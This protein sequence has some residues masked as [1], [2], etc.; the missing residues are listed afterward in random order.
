MTGYTDLAALSAP[1]APVTADVCV[2][3]A[4]AAGLYLAHRLATRGLHVVIVEAGAAKCGDGASV[5][6]DAVQP[7]L[8]Y[9]GATAGRAF[10]LGG[11]TSRWGGLLVPHSE[12]DLR[13]DGSPTSLAW[14]HIV[15]V[16][17][18]RTASV[19]MA[20]G[21]GSRPEFF[22]F[23]DESL[24][25]TAALLRRHG[26]T[27]IASAF[28]PWRLRNLA[29]PGVDP[30]SWIH[31]RLRECHRHNVVLRIE[32]QRRRHRIRRGRIPQRKPTSARGRRV[33]RRRRG[34]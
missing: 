23:A 10:G 18:E 2:I 12:V 16:V 19:T 21:L 1:V 31:S 24:G 9:G 20:L 25:E 11:S 26:L 27:P 14:K 13:D 32:S 28:L 34:H 5:G 15:D 17:R 33:R 29:V 4:G 7:G 3:G 22:S 6:I 30:H 8:P